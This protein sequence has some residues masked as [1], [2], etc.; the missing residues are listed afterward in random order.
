MR[1]LSSLRLIILKFERFMSLWRQ[2]NTMK[3]I[4]L[5]TALALAASFT[6]Q[7]EDIKPAE[8]PPVPSKLETC[9]VSGEKFGGDMGQ[10]YVFT[11]KNQEVKLCCKS[12]KKTFD[13]NPDKFMAKIRAA[14]QP[15]KTDKSDKQ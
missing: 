6:T 9:A 15:A 11:Y 2:T 10:P 14:D 13:K 3:K 12:C 8:I 4:L 5:L 1:P 7:A